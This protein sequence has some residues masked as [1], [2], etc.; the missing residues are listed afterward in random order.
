MFI[1]D[2]ESRNKEYLARHP[3]FQEH[4]L[5]VVLKD[6]H[7][8]E[9]ETEIKGL[10]SKGSV[11][12]FSGIADAAKTTVI[13][14][15]CKYTSTGHF[16]APVGCE[17]DLYVSDL[18][19]DS[20][21]DC[22]EKFQELSNEANASHEELRTTLIHLENESQYLSSSF[23]LFLKCAILLGIALSGTV[24]SKSQ[25]STLTWR[26][27]ISIIIIIVLLFLIIIV[28]SLAKWMKAKKTVPEIQKK[29]TDNEIDAEQRF[30]DY[31]KTFTSG[32]EQSK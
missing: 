3:F 6:I 17:Y 16:F 29:M 10:I 8:E 31:I 9:H 24:Y 19:E 32:S 27:C 14:R 22:T 11:L 2:T 26:I 7:A 23:E 15:C 1:S 28:V 20:L 18:L 25:S 12:L 13:M 5:Y 21:R 4:H 30:E